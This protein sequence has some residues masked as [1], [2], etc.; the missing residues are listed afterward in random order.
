MGY[1]NSN[2]I[3]EILKIKVFKMPFGDA[4]KSISKIDNFEQAKQILLDSSV[5]KDTWYNIMKYLQKDLAATYISTTK[6]LDIIE[7]IALE[8]RDNKTLINEEDLRNILYTYEDILRAPNRMVISLHYSMQQL[9]S[10]FSKNKL[11][12]NHLEHV[13]LSHLLVLKALPRE[14]LDAD[15][16]LIRNVANALLNDVRVVDCCSYCKAIMSILPEQTSTYKYCFRLLNK[17]SKV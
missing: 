8:Y 12:S 2:S 11:E 14:I 7:I 9:I 4:D 1:I 15:I 6:P 17:L 13:A 10:L 16:P 5:S 3:S